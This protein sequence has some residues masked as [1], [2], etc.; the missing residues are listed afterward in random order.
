[1]EGEPTTEELT[2]V[3]DELLAANRR[4]ERLIDGLLLLARSD[5][6][7][8]HREP[9]DMAD[10]VADE[11]TAVTDEARDAG[12]L[13][14]VT[15]SLPAPLRGDPV[16][17]GHLVGNLLRNAVRHNH[18]G[19]LVE[20]SVTPQALTVRNTGPHVPAGQVRHLFEPFR[21]GAEERT[22]GGAAGGSGLGLSIVRS[23][24][25]AHGG[26][27][28]ARPG[29]DGGLLVSATLPPLQDRPPGHPAAPG[30]TCPVQAPAGRRRA[31][32]PH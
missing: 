15:G 25:H 20:V 17:L 14:H 8:E 7:L 16:L 9:V 30:G 26:T 24:A 18:R 19:G 4:S 27:V 10:V 2:R 12:V 23:I 1:L 6:G 28:T 31:R 3:K 13:V 22:A 5:R 29:P 21:R 32:S 11:I